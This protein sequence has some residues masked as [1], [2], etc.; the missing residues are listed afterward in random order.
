MH[1]SK[2]RTAQVAAITLPDAAGP[3]NMAREDDLARFLAG[4]A[5]RRNRGVADGARPRDESG[6][7]IWGGGQIG[8][9]ER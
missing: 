9:V 6:R 2:H 8:E 1:M 3:R 4:R 7:T 5:V